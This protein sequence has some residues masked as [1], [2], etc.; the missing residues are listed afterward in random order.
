MK[1][2]EAGEFKTLRTHDLEGCRLLGTDEGL[3]GAED[4]HFGR[5]GVALMSSDDRWYWETDLL[6]NFSIRVRNAK[7]QGGIFSYDPATDRVS[8]LRHAGNSFP[9]D[10]HPHGISILPR[11]G[12][13]GAEDSGGATRVFAVNHRKDGDAVE[14]FEAT[15][16]ELRH[17]RSV[18]SSLWKNIN[19]VAAAGG[20]F[21]V[22]NYM[23]RAPVTHPLAIPELL[24]LQV[25]IG[26]AGYVLWCRHDAGQGEEPC[27]RVLGGLR[28][29]NGVEL[30]PDGRRVFV[31]E[32]LGQ[33]VVSY[34]VPPEGH[35]GDLLPE[36]TLYL[37]SA[38]DNLSL[39]PSG[40][41]Y[42]A[43]HPKAMTLKFLHSKRPSAFRSPSQVIS[44]SQS[45]TSVR[46]EL[47]S[48]DGSPLSASSAA[49]FFGS[50]LL[51]GGIHDPGFLAC[52]GRTE[53]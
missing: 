17:V 53:A 8:R 38:C 32:S 28:M 3:V 14:V 47:L 34:N 7:A 20:G 33:R 42:T 39:S 40:R 9:R 22:T 41:V 45:L 19:D 13:E 50:S 26:A 36:K 23:E 2:Y 18:K 10:F 46:E 43:C 16:D 30:S 15:P 48:A 29:P 12:F 21:Y 11:A 5:N 6:Q 51:V 1:A 24:N 37:G 4:I 31:V 49:A 27:V 52:P 25:E 44:F 35:G